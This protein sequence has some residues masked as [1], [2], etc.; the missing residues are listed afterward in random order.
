MSMDD[1]VSAIVRSARNVIPDVAERLRAGVRL[2]S[3]NPAAAQDGEAGGEGAFQQYFAGELERVGCRVRVWEPD[4]DALR[5]RYPDLEHVIPAEG[6]AGRPNVVGW[7]PAEDAADLPQSHLLLNSHA[8]T[9]GPGDPGSWPAP[10]FAGALR[11]GKIV[12]LGAADAKGCLFTFLGALMT[13]RA[14]GIR[15]RRRVQVQSVIGEESGGAGTLECLREG[16]TATAAMVGEPTSMCLCLG[17]LGSVD[18]L[19]R[20]TGRKAHPGEGWRGVNA[21]GLA[22]RYV[23]AL[24]RLRDELDRTNMHPLWALLP[25]GHVWNLMALNSGPTGRAV[26]DRCNLHYSVGLIGTESGSDVERRVEAALAAVT[27]A[28]PW[29]VAHPPEVRWTTRDRWPAVTDPGHPAA[30][31]MVAAGRAL[32]EHGAAPR[33][34]SAVADTR[35]LV[36][37]GGIPTLT[38][39]PGDIHHCH[40]PAEGLAVDELRR[41]VTWTALFLARYCGIR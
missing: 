4:A 12:G 33:G 11:D 8:D 21:I 22:W 32:G 18:L 17:T 13:L 15:L 20:V 41:A 3:V 35:H 14:A 36:R 6:F 25:Q 27:A 10:P 34:F 1:L 5:E 23:E 40:G 39:G 30:V 9:V 31:A 24:E 2:P 16:Y 26:P 7:A 28:D 19:I 38:F 37:L 29:L